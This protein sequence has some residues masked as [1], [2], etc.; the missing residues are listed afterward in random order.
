[1]LNWWEKIT[2]PYISVT[3]DIKLVRKYTANFRSLCENAAST[4]THYLKKQST[5]N[6][7]VKIE[8]TS[9]HYVKI[10]SSS[11]HY[12]KIVSYSDHYVKIV[13]FRPLCENAEST[14]GHYVPMVSTSDHCGK[15]VSNSGH[16][17][18]KASTSGTICN[19][20]LGQQ[21]R[22][23]LNA[24]LDYHL[25]SDKGKSSSCISK[26][27]KFP[28]ADTDLVMFPKNTALDLEFRWRTLTGLA[29]IPEHSPAT[30]G[31]NI[32]NT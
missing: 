20:S 21:R 29:T 6:H 22:L 28:K 2:S 15:K 31:G 7:H 8:L 23:Q 9:D 27:T 16:Y 12:V 5:C 10:V 17:V 11:D 13:I 14:S 19:R 4:S 24:M 32:Y 25:T 3:I 26:Y 1:M 18:K 30:T